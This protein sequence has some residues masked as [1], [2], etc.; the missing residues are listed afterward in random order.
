[1]TEMIP[2]WMGG[3]LVAVDALDVHKRG[4]RHRAVSVFV[5]CDGALLL[6]R[7]SLTKAHTPGLWSAAC[8]S[9]LR[10]GEA[11]E[12]C[13]IRHLRSE[14]GITMPLP[15]KPRPAIEYRADVGAG[16]TD[17]EVVDIFVADLAEKPRIVLNPDKV[18]DV[19]WCPLP[20]LLTAMAAAPQD[21]TPW[22]QTCMSEHRD[23]IFG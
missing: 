12:A 10:W 8:C 22:L 5:T 9:H 1:M 19:V 21:Y 6:Q 4:L 18:M 23:A 14:L 17:H 3:D 7:R 15:L 13:A 20:G 2:T 16:M 11:P